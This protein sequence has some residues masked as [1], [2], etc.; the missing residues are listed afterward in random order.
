MTATTTRAALQIRSRALAPLAVVFLTVGLS[1][2]LSFPFLSLFLT[3][4]VHAGPVELSVF[5]LAQPLSGIVVSTVLGRLSDGRVARRRVLMVCAV[6]GCTSA[7]LFSVLRSY[8]LLLVLACTVTSVAGALMPQG[9]AYA[10]AVL[11]D[12]PSA[13]MV[14]N[15]LRTFFSLSWV[16]GPPLASLL[17]TTGGFATLYVCS[18][19]LY[20]VVLAVVVLW[21]AEPAVAT[22]RTKETTDVAAPSAGA[23]RSLWMTLAALVLLQ[24]AISL[25]VQAIP[26]L[27]R[28]ELHANVGSAGIVLGVCAALEIPAMLGF[29]ALST[30]VPLQVLVRIGPLFGIAYYALASLAGQV[31]QLGAAQLLDACFIAVIQGLAISY[32]QELLPF[33]PGRASTLYS[34]TFPCGAI[35]ASPLL[36][37]GAEFGY[38]ITFVSAVGLSVGGLVL[39][40]ASPPSRRSIRSGTAHVELAG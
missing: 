10:R 1:G 5:L 27:V 3:S 8:W 19:V 32:V 25:N 17:L 30:R 2:A 28:H 40:L 9:F 21:L 6:A 16:A 14:T 4:A 39:L 13:P 35:L 37:L 22:P 23:R 24:S 38:R 12:D 20:A 31:W 33:Q 18:A 15:T 29:G 34:N 36:G 26:L 11:G 7:S